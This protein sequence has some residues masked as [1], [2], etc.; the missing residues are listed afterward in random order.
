M[1]Q[2][3]HTRHFHTAV[4]NTS[5]STTL[6]AARGMNGFNP[7]GMQ[8]PLLSTV[9]TCPRGLSYNVLRSKLHTELH[10]LRHAYQWTVDRHCIFSQQIA[11]DPN[12]SVWLSLA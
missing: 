7:L 8:P 6:A 10:H 5:H 3:T 12:L 1:Y 9:A 4:F 2:R 11:L